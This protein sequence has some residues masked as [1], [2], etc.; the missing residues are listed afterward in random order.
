[1][2][3]YT[4]E[5]GGGS[6]PKKVNP[7]GP[8]EMPHE[9]REDLAGLHMVLERSGRPVVIILDV[10]D[11]RDGLRCFARF[12]TGPARNS[13]AFLPFDELEPTDYKPYEE[14]WQYA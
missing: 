6:D 5:Q 4:M 13:T 12:I 1:M 10:H 11:G 2:P 14:S 9:M 8:A 3:V 7:F